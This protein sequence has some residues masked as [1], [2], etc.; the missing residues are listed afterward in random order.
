MSVV[1]WNIGFELSRLT[2]ELEAWRGDITKLCRSG[3]SLVLPGFGESKDVD[4][5]RC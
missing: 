2:V 4:I 3:S 5:V 1:R